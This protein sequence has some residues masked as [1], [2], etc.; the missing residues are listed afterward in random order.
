MSSENFIRQGK[1]K[2]R[3]AGLV[4]QM[5]SD[6]EG[7]LLPEVPGLGGAGN[8]ISYERNREALSEYFIQ[9]RL[10]GND[11]FPD[12]SIDLFG[13]KL[14]MP[15]LAAPM[16]GIA[17]NLRG[18]VE[19]E[20]FLTMVL[21]GCADAGT[22]GAFGDSYDTTAGYIGAKLMQTNKGIAVL[23]PRIF[24]EIS[25]RIEALKKSSIVAIGLDLD[26]VTGLLLESRRV[27]R[28]SKQDL[29]EIRSLFPGPM[30]LKGILNVEDASVAYE[31]GFDGVVVSN[32]GGRSIDY[33]PAPATVLPAIVKKFKGKL[34]ILAD[35][36][37][38][39]GYDAF[40]Y[41]ALGA[42]AVMVGRTVLYGAVGGGRAGVGAVV[43][44]LASEL[45]RAMVVTGCKNVEEIGKHSIKI[46]G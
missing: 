19:E 6:Q 39:N 33:C 3:A 15:I 24:E 23:K 27:G 38:R 20:E 45:T 43:S 46:Y 21:E 30:F 37:I 13:Q 4:E 25:G 40:I 26:G 35:G 10:V 44:Q 12:T 36:G 28:K 41:L 29:K 22:L 9:P 34:K 7:E 14:S 8:G 5:I 1:D 11:F 2:L 18:L 31:A 16:S 32:H 42:D 17:T